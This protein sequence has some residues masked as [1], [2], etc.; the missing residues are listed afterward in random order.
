MGSTLRFFNRTLA[1]ILL[2]LLV[3][4]AVLSASVLLGWVHLPPALVGPKLAEFSRD[5]SQL[6]NLNRGL[7]SA[8]AVIIALGSLL[9]L[10][11]ELLPR[12]SGSDPFVVERSELGD[13]SIDRQ[14]IAKLVERSLLTLSAVRSVQAS[15]G[16]GE[17]GLRVWCAV[18]ADANSVLPELG[19]KIQLLVKERIEGQLGLGVERVTT[20]VRFLPSRRDHRALL[21]RPLSQDFD[22]AN[23]AMN[24]GIRI[25][26]LQ[27]KT[28]LFSG[29]P[30]ST[31]A[32]W[33]YLALEESPLCVSVEQSHEVYGKKRH[34]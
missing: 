15:V 22:R 30:Q 14:S 10:R 32:L 17:L 2:V 12:R 33:L 19:E 11:Y 16:R 23:S 9:L 21:Y 4:L 5:L 31:T 20:R 29:H 25:E 34:Q 18:V 13:I 27:Q 6:E 8:A 3:A 26:R 7:A 28:I 24:S 1:I